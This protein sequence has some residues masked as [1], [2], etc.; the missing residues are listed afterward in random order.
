MSRLRNAAIVL[1]TLSGLIGCDQGG[2]AS[3]APAP[4][5]EVAAGLKNASKQKGR[6]AIP[7]AATSRLPSTTLSAD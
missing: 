7:K 5:E 2:G 1:L 3:I 6:R 4:E